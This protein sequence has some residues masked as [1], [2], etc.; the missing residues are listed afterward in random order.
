MKKIRHFSQWRSSGY[1]H[2]IAQK[3]KI[4]KTNQTF[5]PS[6]EELR[7]LA[8]N[9]TKIKIKNKKNQTFSPGGDELRLLA[10]NKFW[11]VSKCYVNIK[12]KSE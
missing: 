4:N 5:F 11:K 8:P 1:C 2:Q 6:G 7:S 9:S 12:K 3:L 10:R